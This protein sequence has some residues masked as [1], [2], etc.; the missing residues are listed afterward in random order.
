VTLFLRSDI[1]PGGI[2]KSVHPKKEGKPEA[3]LILV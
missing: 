2:I 1:A 3:F